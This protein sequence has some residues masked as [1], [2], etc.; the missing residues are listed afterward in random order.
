[1]KKKLLIIISDA[2]MFRSYIETKVFDDLEKKYK[3]FF[4]FDKSIHLKKSIKKKSRTFTSGYL[5]KDENKYQHYILSRNFKKVNLSSSYKL[6]QKIFL[7]YN[8]W[9]D[10]DKEKLIY[11]LLLSPVRTFNF[12]RDYIKF[13]YLKSSFFVSVR[14]YYEKKIKINH[15]LET[16][17]LKI[18]PDLIILPTKASDVYY[19]DLKSISEKYKIKLLYLV[20]NWDNVSSKSILYQNFF[21]GV[22]GKQSYDQVKKIHN[23]NQSKIHII[24]SPRFEI[25]FKSRNTNIKSHYNHKYILF[26]ENTYPKEII[27]LKYL[28]K[29]LSD[30]IFF[31]NFKII[32]RPHPWRKS[33]NLINFN[34]YKNVILDKQMQK[35]YKNK[36]FSHNFQPD[37]DYYPSLIKNAE[38]VVAGPTT[39]VIESLIFRKKILLLTFKESES[40]Y[41]PH[42]LYKYYEHFKDIHKLKNIIVNKSLINLQND[43]NNIYKLRENKRRIIDLERNYFL[44]KD[45]KSYKFR[46]QNLIKN[47]LIYNHV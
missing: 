12:I 46:L 39:M 47:I 34:D 3:C 36:N 35:I 31:K 16:K 8:K 40:P 2:F 1:M 11:R 30:N 33:R 44:F 6:A 14:D 20:D 10:H 28:D 5:E 41:S 23:I 22:W 38:F 9:I 24:G 7:S 45:K 42:N 18:N 17:I 15:D 4:L 37:L 25:F 19:F 29:I 43:I 13:F 21:Y 32:Y 27:S 26:L